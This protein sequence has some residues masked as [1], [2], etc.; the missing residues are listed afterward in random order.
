MTRD[1]I[2][3]DNS[4]T[5]PVDP[6]VAEEMKPFLLGENYGNP[7]SLHTEGLLAHKAVEYSRMAVADLF[8]ATADEVV[9]TASGTEADNMAIL[10][11]WEAFRGRPFHMITSAIEHPAI[12]ETCRY[13]ERIG[14]AVTYIPVDHEGMISLD[15]LASAF[16]PETRLVSIMAANNVVGTIQ[17]VREM[18]RLTHE[19]G[20]VFHTD[21][22]Q[23][24][25]KI[26]LTLHDDAI[27]LLSLSAH[28]LYGPKGVGAL[29]IREGTGLE[30]LIHGGGQ[31]KGR[32]SATENVA[33]IVGLGKAVS[34]AAE[35]MIKEEKRLNDLRDQ[36]VEGV[37][38]SVKNAYLIGHRKRRLPGHVCL[39][40]RQMEG[41]A[42]KMLLMLDEEGIAVST[43]SAC[44]A[45]HAGEPSYILTAMGFD[46]IQARGS[47]R[48]TMGRFN[49]SDEVGIFLDMFPRIV[50][51]LKPVSSL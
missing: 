4:A 47:L 43:G 49:T 40:L 18:A 11:V 17:P 10:G 19:N 24:A 30:P 32:R 2:Y 39:G 44:S 9:F 12:L 16:R 38:E 45:H 8:G 5:T 35:E 46:P 34:L 41:E 6:R 37:E 33:G 31:E 36:M 22:V 7:S 48:I 1:R 27:D 14:V 21:A 28:K 51:N 26:P 20:A 25:G 42:M 50:R 15:H 3:F 23:A 13:L 29:I